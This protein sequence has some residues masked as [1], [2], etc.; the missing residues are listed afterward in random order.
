MHLLRSIV[1]VLAGM[2]LM[3]AL[4]L[5]GTLVA[6]TNLGGPGGEVT[7]AYLAANFAVSAL[8]AMVGGAVAARLAP[9]R[10]WLHV[11]AMALFMVVLTGT[12]VRG[13]GDRPAYYPVMVLTFGLVG[14]AVGGW[15]IARRGESVG[16]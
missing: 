8:A 12:D 3:T 2:A 6:A 9:H 10:P 7:D 4:V 5:A 11:A 14:L 16:E 15:L 13:G 1:A